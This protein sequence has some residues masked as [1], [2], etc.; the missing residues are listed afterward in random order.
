MHQKKENFPSF[1]LTEQETLVN[2]K[3]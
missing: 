3:R 1:N 2:T